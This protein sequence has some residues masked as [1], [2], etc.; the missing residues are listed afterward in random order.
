MYVTQRLQQ[1]E[2]A[3]T[4]QVVARRQA[5][6][7]L[8]GLGQVAKLLVTDV[9]VRVPRKFWGGRYCRPVALTIRKEKRWS[10]QGRVRHQRG[11]RDVEIYDMRKTNTLSH[12]H[13]HLFHQ[14]Y[15]LSQM[16]C[17][18]IWKVCR[19]QCTRN[20]CSATQRIA[21]ATRS[22]CTPLRRTHSICHHGSTKP[23]YNKRKNN[24]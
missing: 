10:R 11:Q 7:A 1:L 23:L 14:H 22:V 20:V 18:H 19:I 3:A 4:E 8:A 15:R 17:D 21:R 13:T 9:G 6:Q 24:Y 12:T 2:Q 16:W 5:E